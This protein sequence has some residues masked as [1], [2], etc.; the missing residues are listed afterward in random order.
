MHD[1]CIQQRGVA[2]ER[3]GVAH[4]GCRSH[5][6]STSAQIGRVTGPSRAA[7]GSGPR[8]R[9]TRGAD[10]SGIQAAAPH[11]LPQI[12]AVKIIV[13]CLERNVGN[14]YVWHTTDSGKT[15]ISFFKASR[16]S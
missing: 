15:L 1:P 14:G 3:N 8:E 7:C 12:Y 11:H 16:R 6:P 9:R 2:L 4:V 13:E 5:S 10:Q